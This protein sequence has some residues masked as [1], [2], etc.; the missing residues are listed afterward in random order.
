MK[1]TSGVFSI[2][3]RVAGYMS[4]DRELRVKLLQENAK[5]TYLRLWKAEVLE[6]RI[7]IGLKRTRVSRFS[8]PGK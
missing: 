4:T 3:D 7:T 5:E 2:I 1:I 6:R 8:S